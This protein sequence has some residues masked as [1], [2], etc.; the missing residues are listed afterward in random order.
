MSIVSH[1]SLHRPYIQKDLDCRGVT[2]SDQFPK[3]Q[4]HSSCIY[5][6]RSFDFFQ[7]AVSASSSSLMVIDTE[8][9]CVECGASESDQF[10]SFN[11]I[12]DI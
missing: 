4:F 11:F 7:Y 3:L 9:N 2:D 1:L 8:I 6:S 10:P 12:V 5:I